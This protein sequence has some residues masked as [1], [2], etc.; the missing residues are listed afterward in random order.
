MSKY[1]ISKS[2]IQITYNTCTVAP[3]PRGSRFESIYRHLLLFF[4][5]DCL[6]IY[7]MPFQLFSS[8]V[9][10]CVHTCTH[11][12]MHTHTSTKTV[13]NT[14]HTQCTTIIYT[15]VLTLNTTQTAHIYDKLSPPPPPPQP[16]PCC[17]SCNAH[18]YHEK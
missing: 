3:Q 16:A 10:T 1:Y 7:I 2:T 13:F 5:V 11:A 12:C 15:H 18:S 8:H 9:Q 4:P 14:T 17:A 6:S